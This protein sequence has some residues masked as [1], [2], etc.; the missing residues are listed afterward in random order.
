MAPWS[1][2]LLLTCASPSVSVPPTSSAADFPSHS[3]PV[4]DN[5]SSSLRDE[6]DA[7]CDSNQESRPCQQDLSVSF[8]QSGSASTSFAA[9]LPSCPPFFF[10]PSFSFAFLFSLP[11]HPP[12]SFIQGPWNTLLNGTD[13]GQIR[14]IFFLPL[15]LSFTKLA[16]GASDFTS[17]CRDKRL[18]VEG[19]R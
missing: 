5:A 4:R 3:P 13:R 16:A 6:A 8:P 10:F 15:S 7:Q 19:R 14:T 1:D 9:S 12:C 2:L 17:Q 11:P 18:P